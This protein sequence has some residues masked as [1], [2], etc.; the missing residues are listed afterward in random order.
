MNKKRDNAN[1]NEVTVNGVRVQLRER[2]PASK[3]WGLMPVMRRIETNRRR[4]ICDAVGRQV[5][6]DEISGGNDPQIA[7]ALSGMLLSDLLGCLAFEEVVQMVQAI[8]A[9]WDFNID[10]NDPEQWDDFDVL[11]ELLPLAF[12][13]RKLFYTS[14]PRNLGE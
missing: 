8:V 5:T 2:I 1:P 9:E 7:A 3:A 13:A 10:I 6:D 12:L 4:L 11:S 14:H